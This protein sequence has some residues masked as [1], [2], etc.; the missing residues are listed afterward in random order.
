[1]FGPQTQPTEQMKSTSKL[2]FTLF[3]IG[4]I[5][6]FCKFAG[7]QAGSSMAL[8]EIISLLLFAC[9]IY[10][11]NYCFLVL[12]IVLIL[13]NMLQTVMMVGR[14][15]QNGQNP[16]DNPSSSF[17]FFY[18]IVILTF[19]FDIVCCLFCFRA[20][21]VYKY[22]TLKGYLGGGQGLGGNP[23]PQN[24]EQGNNFDAFQGQGVRIG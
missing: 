14:D 21:K 4:L 19:I 1:M 10:S 16:F 22:E 6:A 23:Q 13:F 5:L 7:G 3:F 24:E 2:L 11:Y 20:Y 18:V 9:G 17:Q 8:S 15:I 12:F